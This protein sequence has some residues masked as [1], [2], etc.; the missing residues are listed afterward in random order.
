MSLDS[1]EISTPS[2]LTLAESDLKKKKE[3]GGLPSSSGG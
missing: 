1:P 2:L 3:K